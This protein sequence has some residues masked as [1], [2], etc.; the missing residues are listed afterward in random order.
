MAKPVSCKLE[1]G[2]YLI[3]LRGW[4]CPYPKYMLDPIFDRLPKGGGQVT[5]LVD[6]PS[7]STDVPE[8]ARKK[9]YK[10][11]AVNQVNDGEWQVVIEY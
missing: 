5:L 6:C 10:V 4:M 3:D 11:K 1:D 2:S 9:G 7:A 8:T